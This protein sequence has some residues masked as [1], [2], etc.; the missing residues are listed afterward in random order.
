M[1]ILCY[2]KS[3]I[4]AYLAY[5]YWNMGNEEQATQAIEGALDG[6][7]NTLFELFDMAYNAN[8]TPN[9]FINMTKQKKSDAN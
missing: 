3:D 7:S 2:D 9:A 6:H 5:I 1:Y 4:D 8:I